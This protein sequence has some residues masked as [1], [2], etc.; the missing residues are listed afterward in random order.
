MIQDFTRFFVRGVCSLL[1]LLLSACDGG[2]SSIAGFFP[3][4]VCQEIVSG[5]LTKAMQLINEGADPNAGNGC[6]LVAAASRGQ[7]QLVELLLDRGA[8][9]NRTVSGDLTVVMGGATPLVAAVQSREVRVVQLLLQRGA[10]PRNDFD[11]FQVVIN[12]GDVAMAELLL[13]HGANPNM[14]HP[15][16]GPVY[17]Y[18][19]I[20]PRESQQKEVPPRDLAPDRI[21][22]TMKRLQCNVSTSRG[23]SLLHAAVGAGGVGGREGRERI[24]KLL[25][26]RGADPN[27][28]ELNGETPLMTASRWTGSPRTVS[29]L[30]DAG[31]HVNAM[32]RCGRTAEDY[33]KMFPAS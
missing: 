8:N 22:E 32:D 25:I 21:D 18:V 10:N 7:L 1:A 16:D 24:A 2:L 5:N 9:P 30:K 14:K 31:A 6:A 23:K 4:P 20:R 11:A 17:Y 15:G 26:E 19:E 3:T 29:M 12:F 13:R 27:V 28:H 33:A